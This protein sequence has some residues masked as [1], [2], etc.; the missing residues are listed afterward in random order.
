MLGR[1]TRRTLPAGLRRLATG[2]AIPRRPPEPPG[3]RAPHAA[4]R[5]AD[6]LPDAPVVQYG[7]LRR[8]TYARGIG[9]AVRRGCRAAGVVCIGADAPGHD[10]VLRRTTS[11]VALLMLS[12]VER[13]RALERPHRCTQHRLLDILG[14]LPGQYRVP[15]CGGVVAHVERQAR[16]EVG[17][18]AAKQREVRAVLE[19]LAGVEES[20]HL[21]PVVADLREEFGVWDAQAFQGESFDVLVKFFERHGIDMGSLPVSGHGR[22][23]GID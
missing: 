22:I 12:G 20:L 18:L 6:L 9:L 21:L 1:P 2:G 23:G 13:D 14:V 11:E 3:P 8:R 15:S 7:R 4:W 16:Q 10:R 19:A 5:P 17:Q